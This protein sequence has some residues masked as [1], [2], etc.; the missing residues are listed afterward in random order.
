MQFHKIRKCPRAPCHIRKH[1]LAPE[2]SQGNPPVPDIAVHVSWSVSLFS[3]TPLLRYSSWTRHARVS[4]LSFHLLMYGSETIYA[5]VLCSIIFPF[6]ESIHTLSLV[7]LFFFHHKPS[8]LLSLVSSF[9]LFRCHPYVFFFKL[10]SDQGQLHK[11]HYDN[12]RRNTRHGLHGL[13]PQSPS[14]GSHHVSLFRTQGH[15]V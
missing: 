4:C 12:G 6:S 8:M 7:S 13:V 2:S 5:F 11:D 3:F 14:S 15:D 10:R 9:F 1:S